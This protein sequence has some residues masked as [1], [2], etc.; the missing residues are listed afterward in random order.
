VEVL[1]LLVVDDAAL[2]EVDQEHLARLQ[3]PLPDDLVLGDRQHAALGGHDDEVVVGDQVARRAQAVAVERRA[4]LLAVGEDH[5]RRPVPGFEHRRVVFV[6]RTAALVHQRVLL[7]GL[8]DHHHRRMRQRVAGH[9]QQLERV[10]EGRGV[11]LVGKADR[12][13][14]GQVVAEHG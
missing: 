13:E 4:D 3:A 14:L 10:V 9:R 6:E 12:V 7:P 2:L 1:E 11:A 5:R 8:G